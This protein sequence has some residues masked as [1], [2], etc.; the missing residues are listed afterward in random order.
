MRQID[1]N[2]DV[3]SS[4]FSEGP[5]I[6]NTTIVF[7]TTEINI[8]EVKNLFLSYV[9]KNPPPNLEFNITEGKAIIYFHCFHV[10]VDLSVWLN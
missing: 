8:S 5:V 2:L 1:T 7:N 3:T 4:F 9:K 6:A 10:P